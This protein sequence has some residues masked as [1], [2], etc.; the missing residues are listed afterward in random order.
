MH[1]GPE[2][3][4]DSSHLWGFCRDNDS[5]NQFGILRRCDGVRDKR[6]AKE[7]ADVFIRQAFGVAARRDN[8]NYFFLSHL[9]SRTNIRRGTDGSLS[10]GQVPNY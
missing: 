8:C 5:V 4:G 10:S 6:A 1:F 7:R 3:V 9:K 2:F